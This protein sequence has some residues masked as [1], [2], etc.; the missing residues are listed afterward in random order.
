MP[1]GKLGE[2]LDLPFNP[3]LSFDPLNLIANL[4]SFL[5]INFHKFDI[6]YQIVYNI[7]MY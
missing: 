1:G 7:F 5:N 6:F 3:F 2:R 4:L